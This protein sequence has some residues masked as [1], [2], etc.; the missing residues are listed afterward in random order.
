MKV[1]IVT[2]PIGAGKSF[3]SEL[4]KNHGIPVYDC[5]SCAKALYQS[6]KY[7]SDMVTE[8]LFSNPDKLSKLENALF[9]VL[10]ED[11]NAWTRLQNSDTVAIESA[12]M[13]QK[14]Y[15]DGFGDY[16]LL[17]DA[18]QSLR[19]SRVLSRGGI[20]QDSLRSRMALQR[21]QKHNPRVSFIL[22]NS[23]LPEDTER[24]LVIFL[25]S[26]NYVNTKN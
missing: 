2:G 4:L 12:T 20:N 13:L 7:L 24:Q 3:V 19:F 23:G 14:S 6:H 25:K 11:F 8:D 10:M 1:I 5:D 15:F 22:D 17:V 26:I 21:D 18:P 9:P 16:V